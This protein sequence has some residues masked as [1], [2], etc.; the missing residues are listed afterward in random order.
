MTN[1]HGVHKLRNLA[2]DSNTFIGCNGG[3]FNYEAQ[4]ESL[5]VSFS[6]L[7][8]LQPGIKGC[9]EEKT[10]RAERKEGKASG[11]VPVGRVETSIL[12]PGVLVTFSPVQPTTEVKSVEMHHESLAEA[13]PGE[14]AEFNIKNVSVKDISKAKNFLGEKCISVTSGSNKRQ[15]DEL[16]LI[17]SSVEGVT[18]PTTITQKTTDLNIKA[19]PG[20]PFD[21]GTSYQQ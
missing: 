9:S 4:N 5:D 19:Q 18:Q 3:C 16:I 8:M 6:L 17:G 1:A 10:A 15:K 14:N 13:L 11:T 12:K 20:S 7:A 21:P 2:I